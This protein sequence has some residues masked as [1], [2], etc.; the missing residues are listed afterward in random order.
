[1]KTLIYISKKLK[2]LQWD[3][4]NEIHTYMSLYQKTKT[5]K[6]SLKQREN[7]ISYTKGLQ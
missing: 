5:K 7:N 4:L 6:E 3:K 2:K 1:M